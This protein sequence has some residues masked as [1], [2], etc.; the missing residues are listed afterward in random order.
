MAR[1]ASD[2]D[3]VRVVNVGI[4]LSGLDSVGDVALA[5]VLGVNLD[6]GV[7]QVG[8]RIG[9]VVIFTVVGAVDIDAFPIVRVGD[10]D[11]LGVSVSRSASV[12]VRTPMAADAGAIGHRLKATAAS[13][14][15]RM[16]LMRRMDSSRWGEPNCGLCPCFDAHRSAR[17]DRPSTHRIQHDSAGSDC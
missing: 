16:L 8:D 11:R 17:T 5:V 15:A 6:V 12:M 3:A 4:G 13:N 1:S 9:V 2:F 7:G 14:A 10:D